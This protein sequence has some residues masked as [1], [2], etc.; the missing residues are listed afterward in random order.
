MTPFRWKVFKQ[1]LNIIDLLAIAPFFFEL[2]L[3]ILGFDV[4]NLSDLKGTLLAM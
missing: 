1:A 4:E 3:I 2:S